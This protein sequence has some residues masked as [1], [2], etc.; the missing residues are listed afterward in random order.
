VGDE[1]LCVG[2]CNWGTKD[3]FYCR[4]KY[5]NVN[6]MIMP[7]NH[8]PSM[9]NNPP[10]LSFP[11]QQ[12]CYARDSSNKCLSSESECPT[13]FVNRGWSMCCGWG[14]Y[15][16]VSSKKCDDGCNGYII[17]ERFCVRAGYIL[18]LQNSQP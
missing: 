11:A 16:Q 2:T 7:A 1:Y 8:Y 6:M 3:S 13:R 17:F 14:E 9:V 12:C 15:Y 10:M 18:N 5:C 4:K